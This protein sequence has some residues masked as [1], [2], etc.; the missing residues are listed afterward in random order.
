MVVV[1]DML[2]PPSRASSSS[3]TRCASTSLISIS[4]D[5]WQLLSSHCARDS[6]GPAAAVNGE[7]VVGLYRRPIEVERRAR[8][9]STIL[10]LF[11]TRW[12]CALI[13]SGPMGE[14][15]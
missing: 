11:R 13:V 4:R 3:R 1:V 12:K 10:N 14:G 15:C 6:L 2:Q 7:W 9:S 8:R 5:V